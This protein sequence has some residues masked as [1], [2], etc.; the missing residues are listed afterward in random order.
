MP[1]IKVKIVR[2]RFPLARRRIHE[3]L[4]KRI[5]RAAK[6]LREHLVHALENDL[7]IHSDT[8]ALAKSLYVQTPGGSDYED[9][10][11]E[12]EEAYLNGESRWRDFVQEFVSSEAYT[13]EHFAERV[14]EEE[15]LPEM[16]GN[17]RASVATMLAWGYWWQYGHNNAFTGN[18][19]H[20]PWMDR[21][22][23]EYFVTGMAHCFKDLLNEGFNP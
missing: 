21:V 19:E 1:A 2:N 4:Q 10:L 17:P 3:S 20:R 16:G 5:E 7:P 13:A 9:R 8:E 18:Y 11:R 22:A 14:A 23:A 12:A 6:E 15:A